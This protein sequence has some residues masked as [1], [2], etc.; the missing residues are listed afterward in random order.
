MKQEDRDKIVSWRK[1]TFLDKIHSPGVDQ[2]E[3][4]MST[5][6]FSSM[7]ASEMSIVI[8]TLA[9]WH[10]FL[11]SE[12]GRAF[13]AVQWNGDSLARAKLN[14]VKPVHDATKVKIDALKKIYDYKVKT[15][16]SR[17]N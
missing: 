5:S 16:I 9:N 7:E 2:L 6:D 14:M 17:G 11:A 3:L 12:M 1:S 4:V 13:A 10:L 15:A 8:E